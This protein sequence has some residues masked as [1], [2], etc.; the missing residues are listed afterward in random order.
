M[1][2]TSVQFAKAVFH[3]QKI[4]LGTQAIST[5]L[6]RWKNQGPLRGVTLND[7]LNTTL[8]DLF[9]SLDEFER[10]TG[11]DLT[12]AKHSHTQCLS[13]LKQENIE[14]LHVTIQKLYRE[15]YLEKIIE[16]SKQ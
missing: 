8:N 2:A 16:L 5:F 3:G 11:I 13:Y 4:F 9:V 7:R 1:K 6:N 14:K 15:D 12:E 10:I